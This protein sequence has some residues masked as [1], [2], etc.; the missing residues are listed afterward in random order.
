MEEIR[1]TVRFRRDGEYDPG[2]GSFLCT[3]GS[4][5]FGRLGEAGAAVAGMIAGGGFTEEDI[6]RDLSS[7]QRKLFDDFRLCLES[8]AENSRGEVLAVLSPSCSPIPE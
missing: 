4:C 3:A 1:L 6:V 7:G 5:H 2:R 8:C